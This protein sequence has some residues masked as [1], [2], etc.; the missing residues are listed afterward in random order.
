MPTTEFN[1]SSRDGQA[2]MTKIGHATQS[3]PCFALRVR[4]L[5]LRPTPQMMTQACVCEEWTSIYRISCL[6]MITV[7]SNIHNS[8]MT[9]SI[10]GNTTHHWQW[11]ESRLKQ[12]LG[13]P[14]PSKLYSMFQLSHIGVNVKPI[15]QTKEGVQAALSPQTFYSYICHL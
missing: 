4:S 3:Y 8:T 12:E 2:G 1:N 7:F 13:N 11:S 9:S 10:P 5:P 6:N 14:L 15:L